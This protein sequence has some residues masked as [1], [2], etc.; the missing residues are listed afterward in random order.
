MADK[1]V[2]IS[3][4]A[5]ESGA[6]PTTVSLVLRDKGV[7][8]QDTRERV[9][10]AAQSLGYERKSSKRTEANDLATVALLF[11]AH[12]PY[13]EGGA[14]GVNPFYSWVLTG[15]E[16]TA[17]TRRMNLLYGTLTVD[18]NNEIVDVPRHLLDQQLDGVIVVGALTDDD[19]S[20]LLFPLSCPVVVVDAP[21]PSAR[22]DVVATDNEGGAATATQHL[23]DAGH[24]G[25]GLVTRHLAHNANFAAR[26]RG[27]RATMA[28]NGLEPVVGRVSHWDATDA[29]NDIFD[30]KPQTSALVC[31]NDQFALDVYSALEQRGLDVP[32]DVSLVGFDNTD[33]ARAM[34]PGLTTLNVDKVGM[35]RFAITLL[36]HRLQW[37]EAAVTTITLA[38]TLVPRGSVLRR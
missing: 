27:Y 35:G 30:Q 29:L 32:A 4:I 25:I 37:P 17:R 10:A 13:P 33:H 11:R 22:H 12:S 20:R 16:A 19:V 31:V 36:D 14:N 8:G 21:G 3:D 26:E 38:P 5:R 18:D 2:T 9:L 15:M 24:A 23:I 28:A 7:I 1:R 6:S 34:R